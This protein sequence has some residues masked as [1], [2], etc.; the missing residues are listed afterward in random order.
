MKE[1]TIMKKLEYKPLTG[2]RVP[3]DTGM[4]ITG[5]DQIVPD[6]EHVEWQHG[7]HIDSLPREEPLDPIPGPHNVLHFKTRHSE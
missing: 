1:V 5:L 3:V 6:I 7:A 4:R 2:C